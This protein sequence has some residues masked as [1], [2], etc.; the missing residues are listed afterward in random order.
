MCSWHRHPHAH[1]YSR[2]GA[3][4]VSIA[5][6]DSLTSLSAVRSSVEDFFPF[7]YFE[8]GKMVSKFT[9]P[10]CCVIKTESSVITAT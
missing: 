5:R 4:E 2:L 10:W 3:P 8:I 1:I 9:V 6:G 7:L